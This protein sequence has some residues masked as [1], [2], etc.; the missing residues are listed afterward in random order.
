MVVRASR[1]G[2]SKSM[3]RR[4]LCVSLVCCVMSGCG[5]FAALV[6]LV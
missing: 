4:L 5:R 2:L 3:R 1:I 6:W